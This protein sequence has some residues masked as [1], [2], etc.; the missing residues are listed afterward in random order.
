MPLPVTTFLTFF[1]S[2]LSLQ[3]KDASRPAGNWFQLLMVLFTKEYLRTSVLCFLVL[4]FRLWW[5]LLS[6]VLE[7]YSSSLSKPSPGVCIYMNVGTV[8]I[9]T[10]SGSRFIRRFHGLAWPGH[11]HAFSLFSFVLKLFIYS[12]PVPMCI[13]QRQWTFSC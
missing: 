4:S 2:V 13:A 5:S 11:R 8:R 7:V 9:Y 12:R 6:L 10:H 3:G 1:L